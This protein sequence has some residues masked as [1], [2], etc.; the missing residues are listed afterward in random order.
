MSGGNAP[1]AQMG[2]MN[3][4]AGNMGGMGGMGMP[5]MMRESCGVF[6]VICRICR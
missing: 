3:A 5:G 4:G 2:G 1:G 6:F